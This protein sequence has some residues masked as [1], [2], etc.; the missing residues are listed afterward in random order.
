MY[1]IIAILSLLVVTALAILVPSKKNIQGISFILPVK[2][3]Q[4]KTPLRC[5]HI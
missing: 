3:L 1:L 2:L 4:L 5:K